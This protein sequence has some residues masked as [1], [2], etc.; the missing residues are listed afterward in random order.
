MKFGI[1]T[2]HH[3]EFGKFKMILLTGGTGLLGGRLIESL[4]K[5]NIDFLTV[6]SNKKIVSNTAS[7]NNKISFLDLS[8]PFENQDISYLREVNQIIHL[9]SLN[10]KQSNENKE[11]ARKVKILGMK[12]LI[13]NCL[14]YKLKKFI[15]ISTAHVYGTGL[16]GEIDESHFT[17]PK[18]NYS[19]VHLEAEKSLEKIAGSDLEF[20]NL[21]LTN[22]IGWP[23]KKE[24][25][26]WSLIA[27]D[28]CKELIFSETI[29]LNSQKN[30]SRD[31]IPVN[32]IVNSILWFIENDTSTLNESVFNVSSAKQT[33]L[34]DFANLI[35]ERAEIVLNKKVKVKFNNLSLSQDKPFFFSNKKILN[36]GINNDFR[37]EDEIDSLLIKCSKWFK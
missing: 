3:G 36:L 33:S 6:T 9:A 18:S 34:E 30:I 28:L 4:E 14:K 37:L 21:R 16:E 26:C 17:F 22:G 24:T 1:K 19:K 5:K 32:S 27:N 31:F 35:K 2:K 15:N 12:N 13:Q 20:Y 25:N 23:V 10:Y 11:R 8:L 7:P 29:S